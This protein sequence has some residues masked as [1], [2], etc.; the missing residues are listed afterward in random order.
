MTALIWEFENGVFVS[1]TPDP[2]DIRPG[3]SPD[4]DARMNTESLLKDLVEHK[5]IMGACGE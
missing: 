1:I 4:P 5:A 3:D 2:M